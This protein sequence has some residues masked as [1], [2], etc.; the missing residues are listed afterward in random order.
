M[1]CRLFRIGALCTLLLL[2]G[3]AGAAPALA[4]REDSSP[5]IDLELADAPL[6]QVVQLLIANS[7]AEIVFDDP[8][9]KLADKKIRFISIKNKTLEKALEIVCRAVDVHF[10]R[11]ADGIYHI[12]G[13]P[14][15]PAA[16]APAAPQPVRPVAPPGL[17][18]LPAAEPVEYEWVKVPLRFLDPSQAVQMLGSSHFSKPR[19]QVRSLDDL[20]IQPGLIDPATGNWYLPQAGSNLPPMFQSP[21]GRGRGG[22]S[23]QQFG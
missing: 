17:P 18:S 23:G 14:F 19:D 16:G 13:R 7:N 15:A 5:P 2:T 22:T 10:T 21:S 6:S 12:S 9:G 8:E 1:S 11:D 3:F 20:E 4:A